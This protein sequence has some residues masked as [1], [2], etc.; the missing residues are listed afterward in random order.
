MFNKLIVNL[1]RYFNI[2]NVYK[3]VLMTSLSLLKYLSMSTSTR[4]TIRMLV[5]NCNIKIPPNRSTCRIFEQDHL[6]KAYTFR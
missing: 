3:F 2:H 5:F 1:F 6:P 4:V